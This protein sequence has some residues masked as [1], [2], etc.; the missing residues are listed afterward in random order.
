MS[1][2]IK[3]EPFDAESE[4][5]FEDDVAYLFHGTSSKH[6]ASIIDRGVRAESC[7]GTREVAEFFARQNAREF[8][9]RAILVRVPA[10][11]FPI[12]GF[13]IDRLMIEFPIY[14]DYDVRALAWESIV[15]PTW[16]DAL[17]I[18]GSV[19]Q[20]NAV[21]PEM[22]EILSPTGALFRTKPPV[23]REDS[24]TLWEF[25]RI[26]ETLTFASSA[27]RD[28][29]LRIVDKASATDFRLDVTDRN[30]DTS[31]QLRNEASLEIAIDLLRQQGFRSKEMRLDEEMNSSSPNF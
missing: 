2:Q 1:R 30:G 7:W 23:R 18:Y 12:E 8:G 21:E 22:K 5:S 13:R 26:N 10:D 17:R 4:W 9:G 31:L 19:V 3:F 27:V 29:A 14:D 28:V 6:V 20:A 25:T 15:K 24:R 16:R 11:R